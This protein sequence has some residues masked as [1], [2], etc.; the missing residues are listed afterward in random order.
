[1]PA[2]WCSIGIIGKKDKYPNMNCHID[3]THYGWTNSG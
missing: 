3:K 1:M 2:S